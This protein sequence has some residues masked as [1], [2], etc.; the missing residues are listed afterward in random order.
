[1]TI[2]ALIEDFKDI[3]KA[4]PQTTKVTSP[5]RPKRFIAI[6]ISISA[7]AMSFNWY[8]ITQLNSEISALKL[9]TDLVDVSHLH[10]A[11]LHHLEEKWMLPTNVLATC[12]RP[13]SDSQPNSQT[14]KKKF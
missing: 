8:R 9:K 13:T 4:L 2:K 14:I 7:M 5:G 3:I 11:H 1:M 12:W 6:S 10:E